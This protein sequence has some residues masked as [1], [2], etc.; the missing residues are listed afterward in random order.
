M[1]SFL[2]KHQAALEWGY[3]LTPPTAMVGT[4]DLPEYHVRVSN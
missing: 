1:E 2:G 3:V 4:N